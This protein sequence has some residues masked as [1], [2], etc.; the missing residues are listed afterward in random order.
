MAIPALPRGVPRRPGRFPLEFLRETLQEPE[1][2]VSNASP[3]FSPWG[4]PCENSRDPAPPTFPQGFPQGGIQGGCF[5][6]GFP[7]G[8]PQG[9]SPRT[10]GFPPAF[11]QGFPQRENPGYLPRV[12]RRVFPMCSHIP[13]T[14][15]Q[16]GK[17]GGGHFSP[18]GGPLFPRGFPRGETLYTRTGN[19]PK[20]FLQGFPRGF[21]QG[22][23]LEIIK[24]QARSV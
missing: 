20:M 11:P 8:F 9:G 19:S 10:Q 15:P 24:S 3:G 13:P 7:Q 21:P 12:F 4:K 23:T 16:G 18:G 1:F 22:G 6:H 14:F 17:W 5:T 2:L